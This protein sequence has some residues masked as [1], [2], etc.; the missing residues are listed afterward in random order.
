MRLVLVIALA[1]AAC[2]PDVPPPAETREL[3][4]LVPPPNPPAT[5]DARADFL[6]RCAA[7]HGRPGEPTGPAASELPRPPASLDSHALVLAGDVRALVAR[8]RAPTPRMHVDRAHPGLAALARFLV[9]A[10]STPAPGRPRHS[11]ADRPSCDRCHDRTGEEI[12]AQ[13]GCANCHPASGLAPDRYAPDLTGTGSRFAPEYL[14]R[15]LALPYNRRQ[16]GHPPT[17]F[18]R[19]PDFELAPAEVADLAAWLGTS[20]LDLPPAPIAPAS[21]VASIAARGRDIVRTKGCLDCHRIGTEGGRMGPDLTGVGRRLT[22][23]YLDRWLTDPRALKPDTAMPDPELDPAARLAVTTYLS[24]LAAPS[25]DDA[26]HANRPDGSPALPEGRVGGGMR[27]FVALGCASCHPMAGAAAPAPTAPDLDLIGARARRD[28]IVDQL[29]RPKAVRRDPHVAARMPRFRLTRDERIAV[30]DALAART[31]RLHAEV[32]TWP[33]GGT[34][35]R[36]QERYATLGCGSCHGPAG[37]AP[38]LDGARLEP[39]FVYHAL[40]DPARYLRNASHPALDPDAAADVARWIAED[41][42]R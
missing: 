20:A 30:A 22:R 21:E 38:T 36:G 10:P 34:R 41:G 17:R 6:A 23:D 39:A 25:L 26:V 18:S 32:L 13:A 40:R 16:H 12:I 27:H 37:M 24:T 5:V 14:R 2:A 1:L 15:F 3:P 31:R 11:G 42:R 35:A 4:V 19:M 28:W 8:L 7:C 9:D 29:D 33:G